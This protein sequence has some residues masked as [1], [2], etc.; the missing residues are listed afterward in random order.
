[1]TC[2]TKACAGFFSCPMDPKGTMCSFLTHQEGAG[3]GSYLGLP[4]SGFAGLMSP[5]MKLIVYLTS[6]EVF[7]SHKPTYDTPPFAAAA[8]GFSQ[9][10]Q[11]RSDGVSC[12]GSRFSPLW[13]GRFQPR[14]HGFVG[15]SADGSQLAIWGRKGIASVM[16]GPW[17]I[18]QAGW[19]TLLIVG[20][21]AS[22]PA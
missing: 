1:M 2:T 15:S 8:V 11:L 14:C 5:R 19:T 21:D 3:Y 22:W 13:N 10:Q 9:R 18:G 7:S 4:S 17:W 16:V 12:R 6:P 20:A